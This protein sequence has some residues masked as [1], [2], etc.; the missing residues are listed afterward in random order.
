MQDSSPLRLSFLVPD[1]D[2]GVGGQCRC[3]VGSMWIKV[4]CTSIGDK[5]IPLLSLGVR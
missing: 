2:E 5:G 1:T 4:T 3:N